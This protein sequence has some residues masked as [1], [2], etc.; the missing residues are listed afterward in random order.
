GLLLIAR[1]VRG[2]AV[3]DAVVGDAAEAVA[4]G[5]ELLPPGLRARGVAV[6]EE[7]GRA[8]ALFD[9]VD[10]GVVDLDPG[11]GVLPSRSRGARESITDAEEGRPRSAACARVEGVAE[12]VAE[13]LEGEEE[14]REHA[15]GEEEPA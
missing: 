12:A 8:A 5:L 14:Q 9:V 11:H 6:E 2:V 13:E 4:E 1:G 10:V 7:Q 15:G 3:V